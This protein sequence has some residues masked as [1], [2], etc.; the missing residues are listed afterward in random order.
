[1]GYFSNARRNWAGAFWAAT[2]I[3]LVLDPWN[4][5]WDESGWLE[6]QLGAPFAPLGPS[7]GNDYFTLNFWAGRSSERLSAEVPELHQKFPL[8]LEAPVV[9]KAQIWS[10]KKTCLGP[11]PWK[12]SLWAS[13]ISASIYKKSKPKSDKVLQQKNKRN[14]IKQIKQIKQTTIFLPK[15]NK[16]FLSPILENLKER[17]VVQ[18]ANGLSRKVRFGQLFSWK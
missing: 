12:A 1:M 10:S 15:I 9:P 11:P 4:P 16:V 17:K 3:Q 5:I 8:L 14:K 2:A 6:E 18:N 13:S 7:G